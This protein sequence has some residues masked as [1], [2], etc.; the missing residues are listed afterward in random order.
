MLP[1]WVQIGYLCIQVRE[2]SAEEAQERGVNGWW[3]YEQATIL[4]AE[5]LDQQVKRE[6]FLHE[7][8]HACCT[9]GNAQ[10]DSEAEE[11]V[12]NGIAPLLIHSMI[13][14]PEVWRYIQEG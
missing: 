3:D 4:V 6:I 5:N 9:L 11:R 2:M 12:V 1:N 10:V 14:Q 8:L 13:E 7:L